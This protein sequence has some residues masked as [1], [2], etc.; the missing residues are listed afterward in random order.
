MLTW[1]FIAAIIWIMVC[2]PKQNK[3][4]KKNKHTHTLMFINLL[5]FGQKGK[6]LSQAL[7][8]LLKL[9][10]QISWNIIQTSIVLL[11]YRLPNYGQCLILS[12]LLLFSLLTVSLLNCQWSNEAC[13][14]CRFGDFFNLK[15]SKCWFIDFCPKKL[16]F[17][18]KHVNLVCYTTLK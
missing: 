5:N 18:D 9:K 11:L 6:C 13:H 12:K 2:L 1:S 10:Q 4:I 14:I 7:T 8:L 17:F 16:R 15:W 3:K